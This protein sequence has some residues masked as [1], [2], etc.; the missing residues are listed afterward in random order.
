MIFDP[1]QILADMPLPDAAPRVW[2]AYSGGLDS[3]V[4]L[5]AMSTLHRRGLVPEIAA[6]HVHHG[7]QSVADDWV[8]HCTAQ[9]ERFGVALQVLQVRIDLSDPSGPE[10]AA[11]RARYDALRGAMQC[12]DVLATAHQLD[13]QAETFLMR[14]LRGSGPRGL[15]SMRALQPFEPGSLWRPLL[16]RSR[17]ELERYAR[18]HQLSW[19]DDPHNADPRYERSWLRQQLTPTLRQRWPSATQNLARSAALNAEADDL[20]DELAAIDDAICATEN[21]LSCA[22]LLTLSPA[23]RRNLLRLRIDA[24]GLAPPPHG[25]LLRLDDVLLAKP[26]ATP[27]LAW[28]G[29]EL[30]R[31]RD[32][33]WMLAPLADEPVEWSTQ[34]NGRGMLALPD[35]CGMLESASDETRELRVSFAQ[36]GESLVMHAGGPHR[37]LKKLFQ[38]HAIPPWRRRRTPLV[39]DE[40][41]LRWV[42]ALPLPGGA[43]AWVKALHWQPQLYA[44]QKTK[45]GGS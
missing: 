44:W 21:G 24:L 23:R 12:G 19:I 27:L 39:Y 43:D 41:G 26:D 8:V 7:L 42:G 6:L 10:A 45:S 40:T 28:P 13:D 29:G 22:A 31:Y 30:R 1:A 37:T 16:N 25:A 11:R 17:E 2:L 33:L 20:L 35:G 5:H 3:A 32:E 14:A 18:A 34:W 36:G 9:C 38:E 4:L 15:A